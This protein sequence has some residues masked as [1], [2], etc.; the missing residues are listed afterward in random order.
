MVIKYMFSSAVEATSVDW[1][2]EYD[3]DS[4]TST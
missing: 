1:V 3:V 4:C 2:V